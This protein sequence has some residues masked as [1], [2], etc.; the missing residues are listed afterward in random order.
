MFLTPP[1]WKRAA[2]VP[3]GAENKDIARAPAIARW[4][5]K[6][7]LFAR[8]RDIDRPETALI[9]LAGLHRERNRAAVC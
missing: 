5:A 7:D 6:A 2:D 1:T 8:K 3:P 9:A 4:P